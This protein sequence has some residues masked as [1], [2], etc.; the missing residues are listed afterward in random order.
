VEFRLEP[1]LGAAALVGST[2]MATIGALFPASVA[3]RLP[4]M[5]A[6]RR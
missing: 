6:F 1:W 4:P 5:E 3:S 2:A